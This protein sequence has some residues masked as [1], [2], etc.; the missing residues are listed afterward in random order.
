MYFAT[1]GG[2][3]PLKAPTDVIA[4]FAFFVAIGFLSGF[5]ERYAQ[6]MLSISSSDQT[7]QKSAARVQATA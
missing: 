4:Q 7:A 1:V 5:S 2:V 3:V 6:D